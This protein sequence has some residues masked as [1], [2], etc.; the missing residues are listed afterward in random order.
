MIKTTIQYFLIIA[1]VMSIA[2]GAFMTFPINGASTNYTY[3]NATFMK[4]LTDISNE[5]SNDL[6]AFQIK[7]NTTISQP[8][9]STLANDGSVVSTI[10]LGFGA[11]AALILNTMVQILFLPAFVVKIIV[12]YVGMID[13]MMEAYL[14]VQIYNILSPIVAAT[15]RMIPILMLLSVTFWIIEFVI[16]RRL[17]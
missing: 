14:P 3:L 13:G 7:L 10:A 8:Y 15:I 4:N 5:T 11:T 17:E 9:G 12:T 1:T 6:A 16:G 2:L